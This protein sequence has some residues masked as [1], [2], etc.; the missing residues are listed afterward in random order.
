M[1]VFQYENYVASGSNMI[2]ELEGSGCGLI[3]IRLD[4]LRKITQKLIQDRQCPGR[5]SN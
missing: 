2:G 5:E 1:A 4:G 3:S